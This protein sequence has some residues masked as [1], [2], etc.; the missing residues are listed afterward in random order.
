MHVQPS[1]PEVNTGFIRRRCRNPRCGAK[2]KRETS[3]RRDAFCSRGCFE[4]HY[5]KLCLVCERPLRRNLAPPAGR[6]QQF[7]GPKCRLAFHRNPER[8]PSVWTQTPDVQR[9]TLGNAHSTGLK[10][11]AKRGRAPVIIAGP[12][13]DL[14]PLNFLPL[15]PEVAERNRRANAA[16]WIDT[17]AIPGNGWPIVLIG[18]GDLEH[19]LVRDGTSVTDEIAKIVTA[20]HRVVG[21][22]DSL[23]HNMPSQ[24]W[25]WAE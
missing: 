12:G 17:T 15:D 1:L 16:Y 21:V 11:R 22:G 18:G 25:R 5:R 9:N 3:N 23:F 19:E 13:A 6:P 7:C 20:D 4:Q 14:H 2:L 24:I 8:F 10:T